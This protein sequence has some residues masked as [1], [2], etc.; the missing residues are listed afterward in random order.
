MVI[1]VLLADDHGVLRDGVQRL[2]EMHSR[3]WMWLPTCALTS[4]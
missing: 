1:K 2:L 4:L 3:P